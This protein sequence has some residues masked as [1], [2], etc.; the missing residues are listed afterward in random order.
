MAAWDWKSEAVV[1]WSPAEKAGI[2][3]WDIIIEVNWNKLSGWVSIKDFL[4]DKIP[5]DKISLKI[6][7]KDS[8]S[9]IIE[10]TLWS[11]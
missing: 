10:V 6:L 5:W 9:K 3:A 4:K 8:N 7:S 11:N 1:T 2:K